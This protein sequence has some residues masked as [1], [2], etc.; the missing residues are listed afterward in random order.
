MS[1]TQGQY[2][3]REERDVIPIAARQS[4][5]RSSTDNSTPVISQTLQLPPSNNTEPIVRQ[6]MTGLPIQRA[7]TATINQV[8]SFPIQ[9]LRYTSTN[10]RGVHDPNVQSNQ[11]HHHSS[12]SDSDSRSKA[13]SRK[14]SGSALKRNL[15]KALE[16][17]KSFREEFGFGFDEFSMNPFD[18]PFIDPTSRYHE[19]S[20]IQNRKFSSR[21]VTSPY[22]IWVTKVNGQSLLQCA[23][24][25]NVATNFIYR[26][27]P[28]PQI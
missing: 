8:I 21:L 25:R 26:E 9:S 28:L 12:S 13:E 23:N 27:T 14:V 24:L 10:K 18:N 3:T 4:F 22:G 11:F 5:S 19:T 17:E 16:T 15:R 7:S 1:E 2:N 6:E 20:E